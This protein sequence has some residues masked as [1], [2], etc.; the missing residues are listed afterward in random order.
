MIR[1]YPRHAPNDPNFRNAY[2]PAPFA[3]PL[4]ALKV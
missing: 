1:A 3:A 4:V 2:E